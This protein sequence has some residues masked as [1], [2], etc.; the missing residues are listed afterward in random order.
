[1]V[2]KLVFLVFFL[3]IV[4]KLAMKTTIYEITFTYAMQG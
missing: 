2:V 1:M 4:I 3:L